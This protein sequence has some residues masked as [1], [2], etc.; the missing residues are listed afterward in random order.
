M[1]VA[2]AA[3]NENNSIFVMFYATADSCSWDKKELAKCSLALASPFLNAVPDAIVS[4][5]ICLGF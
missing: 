5:V 3:Y 4:G 1:S 2:L